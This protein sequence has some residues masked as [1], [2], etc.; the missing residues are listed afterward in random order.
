MFNRYLLITILIVLACALSTP[1]Q[2]DS[3]RVKKKSEKVKLVRPTV[4]SL[5]VVSAPSGADVYVDDQLKERTDA[6]G[7]LPKPISLKVGK[8]KIKIAHPDYDLFEDRITIRGGDSVLF[9]C[10]RM[11]ARNGTIILA[12]LPE[13]A[14][15]ELDGR[16][17]SESE[18]VR[19]NNRGAR[20][21]TAVGDYTVKVL[22]PGHKPFQEKIKVA[23]PATE[24][25]A[26]VLEKL[27]ATLVV[28]SQAGTRVYVNGKEIGTV[29]SSGKLVEYT[30]PPGENSSVELERDGFKKF[31]TTVTLTPEKAA[32]V[33][34]MLSPLPTS[35]EFVDRFI[36][37][38]FWN[39]PAEWQAKGVLH[40]KGIN[41]IG[42]PK[43]KRYCDAE[44][45]FGLR[46]LT[47][48]GAAWVVHAKD[49]KNY[50]LF[51]LTGADARQPRQ[52]LTYICRDG[53]LD[54]SRPAIIPLPAPVELAKGENYRIKIVIKDNVI[55]H[56]ITPSKTG[57]EYTLGLFND[58]ERHFPCGNIGFATP[59][60][61]EFIV[62][63]F[64]IRP[65]DKN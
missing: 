22:L 3:P 55:E 60:G 15:V 33:D 12:N 21:K 35:V 5:V 50:Y 58:A 51:C 49:E 24:P 25:L 20:I 30:L 46:P 11:I 10:D 41:G 19:D 32:V 6:S 16:A 34:A 1:A 8:Y 36:D 38:E 13:Q 47:D 17:L 64:I 54:L 23:G 2:K 29:P 14:T 53:K 37:L 44:I 65:P 52:F 28:N 31:E 7:S 43:N 48:R 9:N 45:V 18:L 59:N 26:V 57:R 27:T 62:D 63:T 56:Y 39:A 40:V 4:G 61:E 42:L